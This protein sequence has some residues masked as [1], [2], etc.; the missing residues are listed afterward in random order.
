MNITPKG[1][2]QPI[3]IE[4]EKNEG[5]ALFQERS[6]L[7]ESI[8][9]FKVYINQYA[10]D[11]FLNHG[12]NV[13]K[14]TKHEAQGIFLGKYYKD[15]YGEFAVAT[16][17]CEG[18][19]ESSHA[20]VG[21]SEECVAEIS[22]KCAAEKLL[23]LIW[24]HT[25]PNFGVFYSSTDVNC[26]KTNFFM[27][28][29]SGIVVDIIRKES[30]GFKVENDKVDEFTGYYIY[31][32]AENRLSKPYAISI[33]PKN[34]GLKK[35]EN[36]KTPEFP[37]KEIL[38]EFQSIKKELAELKNILNKTPEQ[39]QKPQKQVDSVEEHKEYF[40]EHFGSIKKKLSGQKDYTE[41]FE[42]LISAQEKFKKFLLKFLIGLFILFGLGAIAFIY[43]F[44]KSFFNH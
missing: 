25:H 11:A 22:Q 32:L 23:M 40:E 2:I 30:K 27:P 29:Q 8:N 39:Q 12:N 13:Y 21:M 35:N 33:E 3:P 19:G 10:W 18:K 14:Q 5:L 15:K 41:H 16:E 9:G 43:F 6:N 28:F 17:F 31:H 26:L 38:S 20:Y 7:H 1:L 42:H 24:V 37:T 36:P 44:I 34:E 4:E